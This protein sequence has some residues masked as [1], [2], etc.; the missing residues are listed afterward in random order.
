[1]ANISGWAQSGTAC[2]APAENQWRQ[3]FEQSNLVAH[4]PIE[5]REEQ[6]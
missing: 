4:H 2:R 5:K 3:E 6:Q 1:M